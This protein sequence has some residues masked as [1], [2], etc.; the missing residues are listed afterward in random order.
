MAQQA[1]S[2]FHP[3]EQQIQARLGVRDKVEAIGQ[4]FIRDHMPD[5]HRNF[6]EQLPFIMIGTVDGDGRPWASLLAGQPGFI[7]SPDAHTLAFSAR[8]L[9]G[10]PASDNLA[11]GAPVGFLGIQFRDRRRNRVNGRVATLDATG[12]RIDVDQSFGNCPMYIQARDHELLPADSAVGVQATHDLAAL[13]ADARRLIATSDSFFIA[14]QYSASEGRA[15]EGVD[16]SHRG[17]RP[18]FV[19]VDDDNTL[20][21]PDFTGNMHFNTLG[22]LLLDPRAGLLFIDYETRDLLFLTGRSEIVW[23]AEELEAFTGAERLV[24]FHIDAGRRLP[25][26]LPIRWSFRDYS[27]V[28]EQ[29][30]TWEEVA[31]TLSARRE[32]NVLREYS[33]TKIVEESRT[34]RSYYLAPADGGDVPCHTAGQFLPLELHPPGSDE[35][36]RRTYTISNAPDG[37]SLRLSIKRETAPTPDVPAGVSSTYFHDQID[38]GSSLHALAPRG[39]FTLDRDA[40]RPVV[41]ISAGVGVTPMVAMLEQI[42]MGRDTCGPVQPVWFIHGARNGAEHAF[43]DHVRNL[44]ERCEK[45]TTHVTYSAPREQD[46]LGRD[47][48]SAGRIDVGLLKALLP[49]GDYDF[50]LCGPATFMESIHGQL[51][52]LDVSENRIHYEFFGPAT[53]LGADAREA[54]SRPPEG[55]A[56]EAV[57]VRFTRSGIDTEWAPD[58]GTLLDL[59]ESEGLTPLYS[60]RSGIC[61]TCTT[62]LDGGQVVY[63]NPPMTP[64]PDGEA[65]ICCAYPRA[66]DPGGPLALDL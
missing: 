32:G 64:P 48:E 15:F 36:I 30:G 66:A 55:A 12:F 53:A 11:A 34:I 50:Y 5:E 7:Q 17:G 21:F 57:P 51:R 1:I 26:A 56:T 38:V 33:V 9:P 62:R 31:A 29:T 39:T 44:G 40:C 24:R 59:A 61:Q 6:Y 14:S 25:G 43:R 27:P 20:S 63:A 35:V 41:L 18:G 19:R 28:L 60:C 52:E 22:N 37:E 46:L 4:R 47:Y 8:P 58:K 54:L 2:P 10:D 49:F 65:L 16:V 45:I 23:E 42:V 13:D 3:G